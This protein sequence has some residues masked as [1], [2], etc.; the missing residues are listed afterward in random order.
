MDNRGF[1]LYE[2]L[3]CIFLIPFV[4]AVVVG[5]LDLIW[6]GI[7]GTRRC[8]ADLCDAQRILSE[9]KTTL[10]N[11]REIS[12]ED[13][14]TETV[15]SGTLA[16]GGTFRLTARKGSVFSENGRLGTAFD[17]K[18][19]LDT[20]DRLAV[21]SIGLPPRGRRPGSKGRAA[22]PGVELATVVH[23]PNLKA[24]GGAE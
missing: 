17:M 16:G 20:G 24:P 19:T 3:V 7:A 8:A 4:V 15:L 23:L 22:G 12:F 6:N 10:A 14:G 2:L 13:R 5:P 18:V 9:V 11:A 21:V 1:T